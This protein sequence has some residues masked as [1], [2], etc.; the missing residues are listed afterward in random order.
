VTSHVESSRGDAPNGVTRL[1]A[2]I[3]DPIAQVRAPA[4]WS[5]VFRARGMNRLC[6]P[7]HAAPAD[8]PRVLGGLKAMHNVDGIIATVPHKVAALRHVDH[9]SPA[10]TRIGATNVLRPEAD[11]TWSGDMFDGIGFVAGL[12]ANGI[13]VDARSVLLVGAGGAGTA[14]AVALADAGAREITVFDADPERALRLRDKLTAHGGPD[15][16]CAAAPDP[17]GVDLVINATPLGMR[18]TDSL[19]LPVDHLRP[20]T[21]VADVIMKP[22]RTPLLEA[23]ARRGCRTHTGV[24]MMDHQTPLFAE[25]FRFPAHD[26]SIA[27]IRRLLDKEQSP[28]GC[29]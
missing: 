21:V 22:M 2:I 13:A 14:V 7:V 8:L 9:L 5:A 24:H 17:A 20:E 28:G 26:W 10:A 12:A 16:H 27:A 25:F 29:R 15:V 18:S 11:G 1:L 4:F 23:A 19:P 3:G 6:I